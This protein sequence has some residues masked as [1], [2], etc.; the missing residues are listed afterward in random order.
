MPDISIIV[1]IYKAETYLCRCIDSILSQTFNSFEV[2]LVDD[3]SPDNSGKICD[4][5]A[6]SDPRVRVFHKE[7]G[8]VSSARQFGLDHALGVYTIHVDPDDWIECRMLEDLYTTAIE[9]D[10]DM[11]ICDYYENSAQTMRYVFQNS[12][13]ADANTLLRR[14]L[15]GDLH[16]ALWNKLIRRSCYSYYNVHFPTD[17]TL[18][19][20]RYVCCSLLRH[21]INVVYVN[22]AYYHYDIYTNNESIV[23]YIS[24]DSIESQ[25]RFILHFQN[26]LDKRLYSKE[27]YKLK[28]GVKDRVFIC[29]NC[30]YNDYIELYNEINKIYIRDVSCK[31]RMF[32]TLAYYIPI[33]RKLFFLIK[34]VKPRIV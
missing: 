34:R 4:E 22:K 25:K 30:T 17:I 9:S 8:G 31:L 28:A 18:W 3:G 13:C 26:V 23:R 19:E 24:V 12:C 27:L 20:D 14:I 6:A 11:V 1:P 29:D 33:V 32:T 2:L 7:N 21:D 10:A 16:G 5:Y 15:I